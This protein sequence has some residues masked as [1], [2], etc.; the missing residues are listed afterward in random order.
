MVLTQS[1]GSRLLKIINQNRNSVL[2]RLDSGSY[3][4][5]VVET[6]GEDPNQAGL[7]K[8]KESKEGEYI[9]VKA[10]V[11]HLYYLKCETQLH[12]VLFSS[13]REYKNFVV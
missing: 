10:S 3:V 1:D 2:A 4:D 11:L 12:Y 5:T 13:Y 7:F 6:N 8:P 9:L